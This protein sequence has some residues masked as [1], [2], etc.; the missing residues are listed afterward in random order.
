MLLISST[1]II[2]RLANILR[3]PILPTAFD[4]WYHMAIVNSIIKHGELNLSL[5]RGGFLLHLFT[6]LISLATGISIFDIVKYLPLFISPLTVLATYHLAKNITGNREIIILSVFSL[7]CLSFSFI[8]ATNQFWPELLTLPLALLTVSFF[9]KA[10]F[11]KNSLSAVISVLLYAIIMLTHDFSAIMTLIIILS[12]IVF[13]TFTT[14]LISKHAI[15]ITLACS[16]LMTGWSLIFTTATVLYSIITKLY[17]LIPVFAL[18]FST[19]VYIFRRIRVQGDYES[20]RLS[21]FTYPL[22]AFFT[23][24]G[25]VLTLVIT[26][27]PPISYTLTLTVEY[28]SIA[29]PGTVV[30]ISLI[31]LGSL[32]IFQNYHRQSSIIVGVI[33]GPVALIL[34]PLILYLVSSPLIEPERILEFTSIGGALISGLGLTV[35]LNKISRADSD[36]RR[37]IYTAILIPALCVSVISSTLWAYPTPSEGLRYLNWNTYSELDLALWC[38]KHINGQT[39]ISDWRLGYILTG[40]LADPPDYNIIINALLLYESNRSVILSI[41]YKLGVYLVLDDWM[42]KHGPTQPPSYGLTAPLESSKNYYDA[43][44]EYVKIYD[45]GYEWV[46]FTQ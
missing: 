33:A 36:E 20:I 24:T 15:L 22:W 3:F 14:G 29:L 21:S 12:I 10:V 26:F 18:I 39:I 42:I 31:S 37:K 38:S 40:F 32:I 11:K 34:L 2:I 46:Y 25:L 45:N 43:S 9:L 30:F 23:L 35:I 16:A 1:S 5:Y 41:P 28:I 6:A 27:I 19:T 13:L 44:S 17:F 4:P 8:F 7:N